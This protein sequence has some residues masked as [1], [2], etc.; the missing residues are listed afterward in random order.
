MKVISE[1]CNMGCYNHDP[2]RSNI[3]SYPPTTLV[4]QDTIDALH[5]RSTSRPWPNEGE[6]SQIYATTTTHQGWA[7]YSDPQWLSLVRIRSTIYMQDRYHN[8]NTKLT[9]ITTFW[10]LEALIGQYT[11]D[12]LYVLDLRHNHGPP[13]MHMTL[14]QSHYANTQHTQMALSSLNMIGHLRAWCMPRLTHWGRIRCKDTQNPSHRQTKCWGARQAS[15]EGWPAHPTHNARG[16]PEPPSTTQTQ[17][18]L[19]DLKPS[20]LRNPANLCLKNCES[21]KGNKSYVAWGNKE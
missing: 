2:L 20:H 14:M 17:I 11:I 6:H 16:L 21:F 19:D 15:Q 8:L 10:S 9:C 13:R 4:G 7:Q 3:T 1:S 5:A 12:H 18:W